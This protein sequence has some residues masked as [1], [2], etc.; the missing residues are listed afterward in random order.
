VPNY[1]QKIINLALDIIFP[2]ICLGCGK[3]TG[4][5]DFNY[6]CGKCFGEIALKNILE[7]I[8]CNR[9]TRF[10]LTCAFCAKK[11]K[12]DQLIIVAKLSD[13]L[14]D[15]MLKTYKYKFVQD[16]AAPLSVIAKKRVKKLL[17]KGFNLF[18]DNPLIIPVPLRRNRLNWR[19]FNQAELLAKN[20]SDAYHMIYRDDI[21]TRITDPKHQADIKAKE[22]R[23]NNIKNNFAVK[24][25]EPVKSRTVILVDD[26]CTTGATLNECA[27]VLKES[28]AKRIIGFVIARK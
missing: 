10:G 23:V 18:E 27:K 9:P 20:I 7:C 14:V 16:M 1:Q 4:K 5:N 17:S 8:G 24:N 28:G 25:S 11:N 13:P 22:D 15:K 12:T 26:I 3:F 2:K 6:V 21:L 19:G